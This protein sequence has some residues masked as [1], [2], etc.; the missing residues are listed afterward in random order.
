MKDFLK[1]SDFEQLVNEI[2]NH[3]KEQIENPAV[4]DSRYIFDEVL[5]LNVNFH[6]LSCNS[7]S[8]YVPLPDFIQ[9]K[10]AVINS[11]NEDNE[12]AV[13][14]SLHNPDIKNN[15]QRIS[16][17]KKFENCYDWS[18]L[19]FPTSLKKIK[20]IE[21]NNGISVNVLGYE[22]KDIY[23]L[24]RGTNL[25][26]EINLLLISEKGVRHYTAI[27]SL[28]RLL[29]S[30]NTKYK[31]KQH[32]CKHCLQGLSV[33]SSRDK[34]YSYC[35]DNEPVRV[36]MPTKLILKFSDG[37]GQLKVPSMI[38]ADFE[39]ILESI[40]VCRNDPAISHTDKI[41][42]HTPSRFCTYSAFTYRKV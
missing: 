5:Y 11:Q 38:Y 33:E 40:Q 19:S 20:N 8:S 27:K 23:T 18:G 2:I 31:S 35:I 7:G 1:G 29:T 24:R 10:K 14:A 41:N 34:H 3:M 6:R 28:S 13:I 32:F 42:K 22:R 12:W 36:E 25:P 9:R 37:Q 21:V 30:R 15:P 26:K 17:L 39:L 4:M 16:N